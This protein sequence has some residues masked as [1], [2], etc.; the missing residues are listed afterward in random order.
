[1]RSAEPEPGATNRAT[2]DVPSAADNGRFARRG[3]LLI[4]QRRPQVPRG[5]RAV[6]SPALAHPQDLFLRRAPA[7]TVDVLNRPEHSHVIHREHVGPTE[8]EDEDHLGGPSAD[9][10][11]RGERR[12]HLLVGQLVE[13]GRTIAQGALIGRVTDF[14][15][16]VLEE[17]RA[18]FGGEI[19]YVVGTPPVSKGEPLRFIAAL[20]TAEDIPKR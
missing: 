5:D 1:V 20:A 12:H 7:Q 11:H 15:G 17:V 14:Q 6:R 18:P 3:R 4:I 9:A 10:P 2:T 8:L 16:R 13:R 19:L